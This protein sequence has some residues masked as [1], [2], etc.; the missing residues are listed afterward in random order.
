MAQLETKYSVEYMKPAPYG[1]VWK[2]VNPDLYHSTYEEARDCM[3]EAMRDG[4][5]N[6]GKIKIVKIEDVYLEEV[7]KSGRN[8]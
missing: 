1:T 4:F 3:H 7:P 8:W 2:E 5:W 6:I